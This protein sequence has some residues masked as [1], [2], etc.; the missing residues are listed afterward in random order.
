MRKQKNMTPGHVPRVRTYVGSPFQSLEE[1]FLKH[2]PRV[3]LFHLNAARRTVLVSRSGIRLTFPAFSLSALSGQT[4]KGN[5]QVKLFELNQPREALLAALP[6]ASEDRMVN[7]LCQFQVNVFQDG[8]PL[9]LRL[10]L[11]IEVPANH[12]F[13]HPLQMRLFARSIPTVRTVRTKVFLDWRLL[14]S[15][16]KLIKINGA[17]YYQFEVQRQSNFQL[18]HLLNRRSPR[19][20]ITAKIVSGP[21]LGEALEAFLKLEGA[22]A[23]TKLYR[24]GSRFSGLNIPAPSSGHVVAFG[25]HNQQLHFG[26]GRLKKAADRRLQVT[27]QP[28]TEASIIQALAGLEA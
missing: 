18:G 17:R 25:M 9:Q 13:E 6:T 24:S 1:F 23:V 22:N 14:K 11:Q 27:L 5:V 21:D 2:R 4:V 8:V 15:P 3:Q 19:V 20:M 28:A 26:M 7:A 12:P 16:V 10:P